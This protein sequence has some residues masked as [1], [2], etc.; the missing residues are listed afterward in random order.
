MCFFRVSVKAVLFVELRE[1][2]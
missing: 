2:L 1:S